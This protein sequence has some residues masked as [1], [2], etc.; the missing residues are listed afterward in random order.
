MT[1]R[2]CI[3]RIYSSISKQIQLQIRQYS[4]LWKSKRWWDGA[5]TAAVAMVRRLCVSGTSRE[6]CAKTLKICD[7][8]KYTR[9]MLMWIKATKETRIELAF[10][11]L[12][13]SL[14]L[15]ARGSQRDNNTVM[16]NRIKVNTYSMR[17]TQANDCTIRTPLVTVLFLLCVSFV[18]VFFFQHSIYCYCLRV[19]RAL[20]MRRTLK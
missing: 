10:F 14:V 20:F 1:L 15:F 8:H 17:E 9:Q 5:A 4:G 7:A 3:A 18:V 13:V 11:S 2:A 19:S 6:E 12:L 16:Y